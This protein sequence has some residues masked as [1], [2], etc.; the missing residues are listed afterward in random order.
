MVIESFQNISRWFNVKALAA[1]DQNPRK[2]HCGW[3]EWSL[4]SGW[5][6][7]QRSLNDLSSGCK[8]LVSWRLLLRCGC[9]N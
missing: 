9:I 2:S 4:L 6:G 5:A 3:M 8:M 7:C 1:D